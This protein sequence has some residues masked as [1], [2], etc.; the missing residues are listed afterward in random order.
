MRRLV[1]LIVVIL[2]VGCSPAG[3][4]RADAVDGTLRRVVR[5]H[6]TYTKADE[7]LTELERKLNLRD[8]ELL[9]ET[10]NA[11]KAAEKE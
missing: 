8:G 3:Y 5:R 9:I 6:K 7:S 11:A 4:I 1:A 10:L 2:S